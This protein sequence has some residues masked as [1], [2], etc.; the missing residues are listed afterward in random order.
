MIIQDYMF[1]GMVF[2]VTNHTTKQFVATLAAIE[3]KDGSN[4]VT[5]TRLIQHLMFQPTNAAATARTREGKVA[6][7]GPTHVL[8][9]PHGEGLAWARVSPNL[10]TG[11]T[12]RARANI[13]PLLTGLGDR[14]ARVKAY[15]GEV[16]GQLEGRTNR[17]P[18]K[19]GAF[20]KRLRYYGSPVQ[21]VGPE[22]VEQ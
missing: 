10:P 3:V 12:W 20:S 2:W 22:V 13:Q 14:A 21:I 7:Y 1:P 4:W 15:S 17:V 8:F 9:D 6:K 16:I 19:P 11:T 18:S 5:Q